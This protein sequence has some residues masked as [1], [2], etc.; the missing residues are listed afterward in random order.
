MS[1]RSTY[2]RPDLATIGR[3]ASNCDEEYRHAPNAL[4][5]EL[6]VTD[7]E[8]S[9][10]C[11]VLERAILDLAGLGNDGCYGRRANA[12]NQQAAFE[13][14]ADDGDEAPW[15]FGWVCDHLSLSRSLTR[16]KVFVLA[17]RLQWMPS[18]RQGDW[19]NERRP[20]RVSAQAGR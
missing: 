6:D 7:P 17:R 16:E 5:P 20:T 3:Y 4:L 19:F 11:A 9:L 13:W 8:I 15:S 10:L 2:R 18:L 12:V 14:T 1:A